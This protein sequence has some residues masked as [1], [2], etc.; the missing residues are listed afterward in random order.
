MIFNI[1][2]PTDCVVSSCKSYFSPNILIYIYMHVLPCLHQIFTQ[3][4][5][6]LIFSHKFKVTS[7][8]HW[9]KV[10][11]SVLANSTDTQKY[12]IFL[13]LILIQLQ[14]PLPSTP[15]IPLP[16]M[17]RMYKVCHKAQWSQIDYVWQS[18]MTTLLLWPQ[19]RYSTWCKFEHVSSWHNTLTDQ[20]LSLEMGVLLVW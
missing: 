13:L 16:L 1:F 8:N 5:Y 12:F 3:V 9:E 15:K 6:T 17:A 20:W 2:M 4:F 10:N 18:D 7:W 14:R 19:K 11:C